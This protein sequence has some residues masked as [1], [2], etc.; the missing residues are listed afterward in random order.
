MG[1][2]IAIAVG[3]TTV[4][5][6]TT[7]SALISTGELSGTAMLTLSDNSVITLR[8][9]SLVALTLPLV[10]AIGAQ[11]NIIRLSN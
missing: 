9:N 5:A 3:G 1:A 2:S 7:I 6:S 11:I 4:Q 8:N 10:L